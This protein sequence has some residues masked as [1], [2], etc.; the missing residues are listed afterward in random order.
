MAAARLPLCAVAD[1]ASGLWLDLRAPACS[2]FLREDDGLQRA[3]N[4]EDQLLKREPVVSGVGVDVR[5]P[6]VLQAV[7]TITR[8]KMAGE[9]S[10]DWRR[11]P[12][13]KKYN[14]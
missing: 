1:T 5:R 3:V 6:I 4:V 11:R 7:A 9:L 14:Y 2:D 10:V 8:R 12:I 13:S